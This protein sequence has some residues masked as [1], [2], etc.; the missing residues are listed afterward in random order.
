MKIRL[1]IVTVVAVV[2]VA[3]GVFLTIS[4]S[5]G[6]RQPWVSIIM[7]KAGSG[8][9]LTSLFDDI[10]PISHFAKGNWGDK[11]ALGAPDRRTDGVLWRIGS[12]L[13]LVANAHAQGCVPE[14][15]PGNWVQIESYPCQCGTP[16]GALP[17]ATPYG[18]EN[19]VGA[20]SSGESSCASE[21][22]QCGSEGCPSDDCRG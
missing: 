5:S 22:S 21:C 9:V 16:P 14:G 13:G 8:Q 7:V 6:Q 1:L 18:A 12:F 3:G 10:Q 17:F 11:R 19:C 15:C 2:V 20:T 4:K